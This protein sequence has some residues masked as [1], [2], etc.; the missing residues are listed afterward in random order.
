LSNVAQQDLTP[1]LLLRQSCF[2]GYVA[3]TIFLDHY[4]LSLSKIHPIYAFMLHLLSI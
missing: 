4:S 1:A 3:A 2:V